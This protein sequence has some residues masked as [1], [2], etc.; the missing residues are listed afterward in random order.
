MT[1]PGPH[2]CSLKRSSA[3]QL[4][5]ESYLQLALEDKDD[6]VRLNW[7]YKKL[8]LFNNS[9]KRKRPHLFMTTSSVRSQVS[10]QLLIQFF[11]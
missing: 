11:R 2:V 7:N 4:D 3:K 1:A 10:I 8:R 9:C 5:S 6:C